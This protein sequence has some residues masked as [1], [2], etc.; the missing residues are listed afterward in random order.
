MGRPKAIHA[1]PQDITRQ[2]PDAVPSIHI[3]TNIMNAKQKKKFIRDLCGSISR[4]VISKVPV[5]PEE[6]NGHELR[7]LLANKFEVEAR[8]AMTR[9]WRRCFDNQC[10]ERNL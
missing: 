3:R 2:H 1:H 10:M 5:M 8:H 6:W 9:G 4:E 7:V